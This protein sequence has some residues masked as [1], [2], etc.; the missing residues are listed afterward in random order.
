VSESHYRVALKRQLALV[1]LRDEPHKFRPRH[2][3]PYPFP[4]SLP[5]SLP[6]G[7]QYRPRRGAG[8]VGVVFTDGRREGGFER[9][10]EGGGACFHPGL[11]E[12]GGGF[13]G[14]RPCLL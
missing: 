1:Q 6:Q 7:L 9:G 13:A 14:M 4:P 12:S 10:R 2:L 5:P 3:R 11:F 8:G